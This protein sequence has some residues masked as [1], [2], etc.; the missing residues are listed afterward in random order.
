MQAIIGINLDKLI[1]TDIWSIGQQIKT[2]LLYSEKNSLTEL[3]DS[4]DNRIGQ[5]EIIDA[6]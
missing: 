3:K 1:K 6:E 2:V 5:I 4:K